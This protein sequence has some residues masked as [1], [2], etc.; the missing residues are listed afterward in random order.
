MADLAGSEKVK[1]TGAEGRA[2]AEALEINKSLSALGN[3]IRALS[4]ASSGSATHVPFRDS[5]LTRLLEPSLDGTSRTL[6]LVTCSSEVQF[7]A[8]TLSTLAFA[9]RAR[10][11][12]PS[13]RLSIMSAGSEFDTGK[14]PPT[15]EEI[16]ELGKKL[17]LWKQQLGDVLAS[18]AGRDMESM[19]RSI[20][21]IREQ[22]ALLKA[23]KL[24][25][26]LS[27]SK[28]VSGMTPQK[29]ATK[30]SGSKQNTPT[31]SS[32]SDLGNH[33]H[34]ASRAQP[35]S[36][37]APSASAEPTEEPNARDAEIALRAFCKN[38]MPAQTSSVPSLL[39]KYNGHFNRLFDAYKKQFGVSPRKYLPQSEKSVAG[40][41]RTELEVYFA[42]HAPSQAANIGAL[43]KKFVGH[44]DIL[45]RRLEHKFGEAPGTLKPLSEIVSSPSQDAG[46]GERKD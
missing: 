38:H 15:V 8:E 40:R 41:V 12:K 31:R 9:R 24:K 26:R 16:D 23:K 3:V 7:A 10:F 1:N 27:S 18:S 30:L 11:I 20:S 5:A 4:D 46:A 14:L 44:Y 6:L 33:P 28:S 2:L 25:P 34:S 19:Q 45:Y 29:L 13:R 42:K 43:L 39:A 36:K 22:L 37:A 21:T 32:K 17:V 35:L